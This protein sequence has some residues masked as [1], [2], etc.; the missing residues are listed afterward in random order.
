M[1]ATTKN[2]HRPRAHR[3]PALAAALLAGIVTLA[4][5][6]STFARPSL[7]GLEA[8]LQQ[9]VDGLCHG[10]P[11]LCGL[12]APLSVA[13]QIDF[14]A[15]TYIADFAE[16]RFS[17]THAALGAFDFEDLEITVDTSGLGAQLSAELAAITVFSKVDI[18]VPNPS[19]PGNVTILSLGKAVIESI[20]LAADGSWTPMTLDFTAATYAWLGATSAWD[21]VL[22]SGS[23][24]TA[25]NGEK[26]VALAGN[27]ASLLNPGEVEADFGLAV[28]K[29]FGA[30]TTVGFNYRRVPAASSACLLRHTAQAPNFEASFSRLSPLSDL[31]AT[32]L[33]EEI[34]DVKTS[35][36][37]TYDLL[38]SGSDY[39]EEILLQSITA[40][41]TTKTF[42]PGTGVETSSTTLA[43]P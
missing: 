12:A 1:M 29:P 35:T 34:V 13:G 5:P 38:I 6:S 14:D 17:L 11:A 28:A 21:Q 39:Q 16:L 41:L 2:T 36:I 4:L 18:V 20:G 8:E 9:V 7:I 10:D 15:G 24:C 27:D 25:P 3:G 26:H 30:S 22:S 23:G 42:N 37:H 40:D 32:P 19:G 33:P 43:L 31:F